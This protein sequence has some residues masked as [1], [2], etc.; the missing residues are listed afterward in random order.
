MRSAA[1]RQ[2][3]GMF[4]QLERDLI[5]QRISKRQAGS[6]GSRSN[7]R[8]VPE[9]ADVAICSRHTMPGFPSASILLLQDCDPQ[10]VEGGEDP[11]EVVSDEDR[12][13]ASGCDPVVR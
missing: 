13:G 11:V 10:A 4:A 3:R 8:S 5:R 6:G 1:I 7:V 9:G 12:F 2:M